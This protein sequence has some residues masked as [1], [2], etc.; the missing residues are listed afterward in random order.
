MDADLLSAEQTYTLLGRMD[1]DMLGYVSLDGF[2]RYA[3]SQCGSKLADMAETRMKSEADPCR[4][5]MVDAALLII[6]SARRAV[7][8]RKRIEKVKS[9]AKTAVEKSKTGL[10]VAAKLFDSYEE[11]DSVDGEAPLAA[12]RNSLEPAAKFAKSFKNVK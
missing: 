6:D 7:S 12:L 10:E 4:A 8:G 5:L 3:V 2:T 1:R 11:V 9:V